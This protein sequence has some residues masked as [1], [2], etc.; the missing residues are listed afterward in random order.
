MVRSQ[1]K[2][3]WKETGSCLMDRALGTGFEVW[4]MERIG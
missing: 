2:V 3:C 4:E 1:K